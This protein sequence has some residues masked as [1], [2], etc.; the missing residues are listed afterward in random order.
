M[1]E[2]YSIGQFAEMTGI[3]IRT[4]HYYDDIGLLCPDKQPSGHRIYG[5]EDVERLQKIVSLKFC[6][7]SLEQIRS[8]LQH[9]NYDVSV[10]ETLELHKLALEEKKQELDASLQAVERI[11]AVM[12]KEGEL[13]PQILFSLIRNMQQERD[14]RAWVSRHLSEKVASTMFNQSVNEMVELDRQF[15]NFM[16]EVKR[17]ADTP[18]DSPQ[19]EAVIGSYLELVFHY[20][21]QEVIDRVKQIE[22]E[23]LTQFDQLVKMPFTNEEVEWIEQ[24]INHYMNKYGVP[25]G[26]EADE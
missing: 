18:P 9:P 4:L 21:D 16:K 17:L 23:Q 14:Q 3:P 10:I 26:G 22:S 24:A 19:V 20:I 1:K 15:I 25:Q 13:D 2:T 12:Q 6:G 7:F 11:I 8:L 5:S